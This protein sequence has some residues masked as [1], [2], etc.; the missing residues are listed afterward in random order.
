[1]KCT[2]F[3]CASWY[4]CVITIRIN[5]KSIPMTSKRCFLSSPHLQ[6]QFQ[7]ATDLLWVIWI[8]F[9]DSG[10]LC[11]WSDTI[12][13]LVSRSLTQHNSHIYNFVHFTNISWTFS[14]SLI[15]LLKFNLR[16]H[17][18]ILFYGYTIIYLITKILLLT[19]YVV[20]MVWIHNSITLA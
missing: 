20:S 10:I 6:H 5:I 13:T 1:M 15:L 7:A 8:R 12:C 18:C 4:S 11:K 14:M 17:H 16:W 9:I 19:V 2:H 3:K